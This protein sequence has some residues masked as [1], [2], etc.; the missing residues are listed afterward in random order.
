MSSTPAFFRLDGAASSLLIS[1]HAQLPAIVWFGDRLHSDIDQAQLV[2]HEDSAHSY[3]TLDARAPMSL[4]PQASTGYMGSPCLTGHRQSGSQPT[5]LVLLEAEQSGQTLT[6]T[7]EDKRC[8]VQVTKVIALDPESDVAT[9]TTSI[10][11]TGSDNYNIDWIASATLPLPNHITQCISQHG[12]WGLENQSTQQ[13]I[14]PGRIDITNQRGRTG[15][16]HVPNIICCEDGLSVD[17]G[18]ALF[19]HLGWSGNY[20]FRIER[21]HDGVGYVQTGMQLSPGEEVLA[22]NGTLQCPP[23]FFT[24]GHGLN[25]CTQRFHQFARTQ[26]LPEWTRKPRPIHANSW[27]AMYFDLNDQNLNALVDAAASIG[28]ERFILDDGW[29]INRR[30]DTAGLGDWSVDKTV[31]PNGLAPLV[32]H[33]RS[34]NMQFGLWFE[35]EMVNPDSN[36]YREHPDWVLHFSD[37]ETPLARGQ[38]VLDMDQ[39]DVSDYLF[40]CIDALVSEHQI[41]YIKWD[42]N[43]DLVLAG[44]GSRSKA[45]KQPPAVYALMK[46]LTDAHPQLEIETCSS[47]GA[48][49]DFGVLAQTGR[50]WT[51]DNIDP[52]ARATI[53]QGFARFFPPE[54]MGAHVGHQHAHL[55]GR[56]TSL[57]TRAIVALQGQF[58]F[59]L[60]ARVLDE[61][62]RATLHHY[63]ELYKLHRRWLNNATYWQLPSNDER[64]LA[65]GL[66]AQSQE[67]ALFSIVLL[68]SLTTT[69]PGC[70]RLRG[71]KPTAKYRVSLASN[72]TEQFT[73][74]NKTMPEW[75]TASVV[76]SGELLSKIGLSLP[77]MPPQA[78]VLMHCVE[79]AD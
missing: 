15:H 41:D 65:S 71:L 52:I 60:D 21:L 66:V 24:K 22:P 16:E 42:M 27:E 58:G 62:D 43:R 2:H 35:P 77:V 70:Q 32:K 19:V 20:S 55:T 51:S 30:D 48:R 33:V 29:F 69:R 8:G 11:N 72:N 49:C 78:A 12:R 36:L 31:F 37:I 64:L 67:E 44:D 53:Q 3:A 1:N 4:F 34:H 73:A 47:G 7:L 59:E 45:S 38:L 40:H 23:V 14:G 68:D 74:F 25:Q 56:S 6:L 76:T 26:I 61:Q 13:S 50:V 39:K 28:A 79:V 5:H 75:C 10:K 9:L 17:S 63:T 57:H 46:K 18:E 54:I